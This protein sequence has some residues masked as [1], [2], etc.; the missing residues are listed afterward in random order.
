MGIKRQRATVKTREVIV[1]VIIGRCES[2]VV[3][4]EAGAAGRHL[5]VLFLI[6]N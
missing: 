5:K 4:N 3:D 1:H 6:G 2:G